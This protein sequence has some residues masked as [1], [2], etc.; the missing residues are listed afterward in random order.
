MVHRY[1][2]SLVR[3]GWRIGMSNA[4]KRPRLSILATQAGFL[5]NT[6]PDTPFLDLNSYIVRVESRLSIRMTPKI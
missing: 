3:K 5:F 6:P 2:S 1:A 4:P